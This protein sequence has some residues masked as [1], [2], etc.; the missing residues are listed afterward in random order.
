MHTSSD[1]L[2]LVE[3]KAVSYGLTLKEVLDRA[4][5]PKPRRSE[6]RN[7]VKFPGRKYR[8]AIEMVFANLRGIGVQRAA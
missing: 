1:Y 7:G 6:W 4:G 2:D 5:V 3:V 8:F